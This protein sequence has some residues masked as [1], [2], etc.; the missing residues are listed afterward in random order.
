MN[1]AQG[2]VVPTSIQYLLRYVDID[3]SLSRA[4]K[5]YQRMSTLD[6][7]TVVT[8][9]F[10]WVHSS[11]Q[12]TISLK[13]LSSSRMQSTSRKRWQN[14]YYSFNGVKNHF[15]SMQYESDIQCHL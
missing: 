7:E 6:W 13:H 4:I 10:V 8:H 9:F 3:E 5:Q 15:R 14:V 11:V 2:M 12:N 1:V